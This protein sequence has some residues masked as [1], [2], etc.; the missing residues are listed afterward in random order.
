ME[1]RFVV[2]HLRDKGVAKMGYGTFLPI[3]NKATADP[4]LPRR[5]AALGSG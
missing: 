2:S 4:S 1:L 3:R 5:N